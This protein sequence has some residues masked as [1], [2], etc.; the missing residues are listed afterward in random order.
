MCPDL[1]SGH[2]DYESGES[3]FVS[4]SGFGIYIVV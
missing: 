2:P 3:V 4:L 1:K